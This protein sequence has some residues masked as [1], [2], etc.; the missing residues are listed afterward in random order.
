MFL[1]LILVGNNLWDC[2]SYGFPDVWVL[3][4][5]GFLQG[6]SH[7]AW[8]SKST[9][10]LRDAG[11]SLYLPKQNR[12]TYIHSRLAVI[13][14]HFIFKTKTPCCYPFVYFL[15]FH[16]MYLSY[17]RESFRPL[18]G[19]VAQAWCHDRG[20]A[21]ML[22]IGGWL[23]RLMHIDDLGSKRK[24]QRGP[25]FFFWGGGTLLPTRVK[26]EAPMF[27]AIDFMC[28]SQWYF[29]LLAVHWCKHNVATIL[30]GIIFFKSTSCGGKDLQLT[31]SLGFRP[32][33]P[34]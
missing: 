33:I 26:S 18:P 29:L 14:W 8:W 16:D 32:H 24:P 17:R 21:N 4:G 11:F 31:E 27:F 20:G 22:A 10:I 25:H 28:P 2:V 6:P 5:G 12:S 30:A 9:N 7:V 1:N 19:V 23:I 34:R 13:L 15:F 3:F